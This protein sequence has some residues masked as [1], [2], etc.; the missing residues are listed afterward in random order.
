MHVNLTYNVNQGYTKNY[1]E[2]LKIHICVL[3]RLGGQKYYVAS[4]GNFIKK[5]DYST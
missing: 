3:L 2:D 1:K 4:R 5:M